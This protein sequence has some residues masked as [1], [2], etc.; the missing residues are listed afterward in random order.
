MRIVGGKH[1]GKKLFTPKSVKTRPTSDR[2]REALFNRL[3]HGFDDFELEGARILDLFAGTG[4][5]G[6]EALSR[7]GSFAVFI[8]QAIEPRGLIRRNI[9]LLDCMGLTK[10]FRRDATNLGPL[11]RFEPFD[12]IF[13]DPPYNQGLGELALTSALKGG[14][15]KENALI[16]LEESK[17]AEIKWP[18]E[19][20]SIDTRAFGDT[21]IHFAQI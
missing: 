16:V 5:L 15:I 14:W 11:K 8:E 13:L 19:I 12:L 2:V 7:G 1:K 6:L 4:A 9:E 18:C 3:T 20:T 10:L 17:N 21:N